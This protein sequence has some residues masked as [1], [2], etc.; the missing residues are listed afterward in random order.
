MSFINNVNGSQIDTSVLKNLKDSQVSQK[1]D[2]HTAEYNFGE[3]DDNNYI[4][5]KDNY[6][7]RKTLQDEGKTKKPFAAKDG[8][9]KG[10]RFYSYDDYDA[11]GNYKGN[12]KK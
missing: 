4:Q 11:F 8:P 2:S 6:K 9:Q 12:K 1:Y 10:S 5:V 3:S 7:S